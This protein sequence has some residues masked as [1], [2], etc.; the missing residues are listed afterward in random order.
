MI[1]L[2]YCK[3]KSNFFFYGLVDKNWQS[4]FELNNNNM[5]SFYFILFFYSLKQLFANA[6]NLNWIF[7][8]WWSESPKVIINR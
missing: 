4:K 6:A 8:W 2:E 3:N 5:A 1:S 7:I